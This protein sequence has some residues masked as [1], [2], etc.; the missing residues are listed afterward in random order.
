MRLSFTFSV[1]LTINF[2][3][4]LSLAQ[5]NGTT[6]PPTSTA[7]TTGTSSTSLLLNSAIGACNCDLTRDNCDVNCCC[8][9][10]CSA[11]DRA[12][13]TTCTVATPTNDGSRSCVATGVIFISNTPTYRTIIDNGLFCVYIDNNAARNYYEIPRQV[14]DNV[15]FNALAS[16]YRRTFTPQ[17]ASVATTTSYY[18]VG[19]RLKVIY[20]DSVVGILSLPK[21]LFSDICDDNNP[22][23]FY[24]NDVS[25]C[26]RH[27][28]DFN[29]E[30]SSFSFLSAGSYFQNIRVAKLPSALNTSGGV[31]FSNPDD[32]ININ[33]STSILCIDV[34]TG[35]SSP[36]PYTFAPSPT[37]HSSN[38]TCSNVLKELSYDIVTN[39]TRGIVSLSVT[40]TLTSL[41]AANI[42]S[43][44]FRQK[45]SVSYTNNGNANTFRRS[46]N[47]GYVVN[48]P[49]LAGK[50]GTNTAN[51]QVI[52]LGSS[53]NGLF[54][55]ISPTASGSCVRKQINRTP[56]RFGINMRSGCALRVE[57]NNLTSD[58]QLIREQIINTLIGAEAPTYVATYGNSAVENISDWVAILRQ[59]VPQ[60]S[61]NTLTGSS[62]I[63]PNVV[64]GIHIQ[65]LWAYTG[66]LANPQAKI[67]GI[68]TSYD[69]PQSLAYQCVG[70][71]CQS[72]SGI[73][74]HFEITTTVSFIDVSEK[75]GS[76]LRSPPRLEVKMPYD[77]FYPFLSSSVSCNCNRIIFALVTET[78]MIYERSYDSI[79]F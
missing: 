64:M 79:Y 73:T 36:C 43:T 56:I 50:L 54:T 67:I 53:S 35:F 60:T 70:V 63:C 55:V 12:T 39:G 71:S 44:Y 66:S 57:L 65:I 3:F 59:N 45:F 1:L 30:C 22:A 10:D 11:I 28:K 20:N 15:T 40:L 26:N 77:F 52:L 19:D 7:V 5:T 33:V 47:P 32:L 21:P 58:C 61:L 24:V 72:S 6:E 74:Q 34:S 9:P 78:A 18:R 8:D 76:Q 48:Q 17:A 69:D 38:N 51:N 62:G 2:W 42:N 14:Q 75:P 29:R 27:I 68:S 41:N 16:K 31:V 37:Y 49:L 4:I 23:L 25:E 46:G 13:F